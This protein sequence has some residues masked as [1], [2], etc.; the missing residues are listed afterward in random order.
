M[1]CTLNLIRRLLTIIVTVLTCSIHCSNPPTAA[2]A[3]IAD[4]STCGHIGRN[5]ETEGTPIRDHEFKS[6]FYLDMDNPAHCTGN[7]TSWRICYYAPEE[8]DT[9]DSTRGRMGGG[10]GGRRKRSTMTRSSRTNRSGST[11]DTPQ[12]SSS[13]TSSEY[14]ATYAVYRLAGQQTNSA[15]VYTMV[16]SSKFTA[17][18]TSIILLHNM[19]GCL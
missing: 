9:D 18:L 8:A 13:F 7:I 19:P 12:D 14:Q 16:A 11:D 1:A 3:D 6:T 2:A 10:P 17:N 5:N 15:V 4:R